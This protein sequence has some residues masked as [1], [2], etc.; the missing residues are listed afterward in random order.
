[1]ENEQLFNHGLF[2]DEEESLQPVNTY[3]DALNMRLLSNTDNTFSLESI[4]GNLNVLNSIV[5]RFNPGY[6]IIGWTATTDKIAV[7]S[8]NGGSV[9]DPMPPHNITYP[10]SNGEIGVITFTG[11]SNSS[12]YNPLY[13]HKGL[14]FS[15]EFQIEAKIFPENPKIERVYWVEKH[16]PPRSLNLLN[17][18]LITYLIPAQ[19]N[20]GQSY[21]VLRGIVTQSGINYGPA[22]LAGTVFISD[23]TPLIF[24]TLNKVIAYQSEFN[25]SGAP[26]VETLDI[27]PNKALGNIRYEEWLGNGGNLLSGTYQFA[28]QLGTSDG[29][30]SSWSYVTTPTP[31]VPPPYPGTTIR[32]Y[33]TYQGSASTVNTTKA[34]VVLIEGIDTN[35]STI[36]VAFIHSTSLLATDLPI[37]FFDGA[38]T[39][40]TM[41]F[42]LRG[43]ENLEILTADDLKQINISFDTAATLDIE[44]N[45]LFL[46]NV[47]T[48]S[49]DFTFDSTTGN[50]P[51]VKTIQYLVPS[52]VNDDPTNINYSNNGINGHPELQANISSGLIRPEQW[53]EVITGSITY[54]AVTYVANVNPY[55]QGVSTSTNYTGSGIVEAIIRIQ[56]YTG[57]FDHIP[58]IN[59]WSDTKGMAV[60]TFLK[61][62]WRGETYRFGILVWDKKGNPSFVRWIDDKLMPEQYQA[63][64]PDTGAPLGFVNTPGGNSAGDARLLDYYTGLSSKDAILRHIGISI[65]NLDLNKISDSLG[66][67][68]NELDQHIDGFS[69]VRAKRDATIYAQG[70]M[71]QT[72]VNTDDGNSVLAPVY[73]ENLSNKY[74]FTQPNTYLV[75]APD[76]EFGFLGQPSIQQNDQIKTIT[77]LTYPIAPQQ[78]TQFRNYYEKMYETTSPPEPQGVCK[79][80]GET[81]SLVI[82]QGASVNIGQIGVNYGGSTLFNNVAFDPS[83]RAAV[84]AKTQLIVTGDNDNFSPSNTSINSKPL[85]NFIRPNANPYGGK[86]D[87]SKANTQYIY[88]GHYQKMDV[89][90]MTYLIG[91]GGI[92]NDIEVFGGDCFVQ[93]FD[94]ARTLK[95]NNPGTTQDTC[96]GNGTLF[97]IES[98]MNT[99]L[100][101]GNH[102]SKDG[103]WGNQSP[104]NPNG[105]NYNG[106]S[107]V[108]GGAI[109][110]KFEDFIYNGVYSYEETLIQY[111]ALPINFIENEKFG[112]RVYYS[113]QKINGEFFDSFKIFGANNFIDLDGWAGD[114]TNLR[115]K[116]DKLFYWQNH[117][118]GYIPVNERATLS[119]GVLGAPTTIGEGGVAQRYDELKKYY[120]N[121]H[122]WGL[123]ETEDSFVW[124]DARRK[125]FCH[126]DM[127]GGIVELSTIKGLISFFTNNVSGNVVTHDNPVNGM[128][129]TAAY[130]S[131]FREVVMVFKGTTPFDNI[132]GTNFTI[133]FN[134]LHKY[135]SAFYSFVPPMMIE[136]NNRLLSTFEGFNLFIVGSHVYNV[137]DLVTQGDNNYVNILAYTSSAMPTQPSI[138]TIHW[139]KVNSSEELY[140]HNI[141]DIA[142]FYGIVKDCSVQLVVNPSRVIPKVFDN[143]LFLGMDNGFFFTDYIANNPLQNGSDLNIIVTPRGEYKTYYSGIYST[144][145]QSDTGRFMSHWLQI[146]LR[147]D[148][149]IGGNILLSSNQLIKFVS[150]KT[151]F[152]KAI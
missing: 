100:R 138:D 124:F 122:Q 152:R 53:Y 35:F 68:L 132:I 89:D 28:Y 137:G 125:A 25:E 121:Q 108:D 81:N 62:Y 22:E 18:V 129:I 52:D 111:P 1:M 144:I 91:N 41:E 57:T 26:A 99:F 79:Q 34:I 115:V 78:E 76:F 63:T 46:G 4:K 2:R 95:R 84:G 55:F 110:S 36:R 15:T 87:A 134:N 54:N 37:L 44:K 70:I 31:L 93:I 5:D 43:G 27:T 113:N 12:F 38:V 30:L 114:I 56:K 145:P 94:I 151:I 85:I 82:G 147:K 42:T 74:T 48:S 19:I 7:L 135:F 66:V 128:G 75:Y 61:S 123:C 69:I 149:T 107:G 65:N 29:A 146:L 17:P 80:L 116:D 72:L 16:N 126:A 88:C 24:T 117:S 49:L 51:L 73:G 39:G 77:Y 139:S 14:N 143:H 104:A 59:D 67:P 60:S 33:Q 105:L 40:S 96:L 136:F 142:K 23:G 109:P 103:T 120:G 133:G 83:N 9:V 127:G 11:D 6:Q 21:M 131:R 71:Y 8:T 141:G 150:L 50:I 140:M 118:F 10:D 92:V 112:Y 20:T 45:R 130:D 102:L 90:F 3:N 64:E 101:E 97:P 86:S 148:N 32:S 13:N 119:G 58:I 106:G 47:K 98:V